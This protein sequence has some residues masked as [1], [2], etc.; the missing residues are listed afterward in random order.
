MLKVSNFG[1]KSD[2]YVFTWKI[3]FHQHQLFLSWVND[4]DQT[5]VCTHS[6]FARVFVFVSRFE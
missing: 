5:F 6:V 1:L 3:Q 2:F 4:I